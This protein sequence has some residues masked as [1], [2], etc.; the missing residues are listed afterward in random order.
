MARLHWT[1]LGLLYLEFGI[2]YMAGL[3]WMVLGLLWMVLGLLWLVLGLLCQHLG[4]HIMTGPYCMVR[5]LL[6]LSLGVN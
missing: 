1:V 2:H 5:D 3:L 6:C 4:S